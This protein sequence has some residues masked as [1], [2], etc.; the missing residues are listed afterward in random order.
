MEHTWN[1]GGREYPFDISESESMA[2]MCEG[3]NTLRGEIG[4]LGG[5]SAS[6]NLR[7]QCLIIRRFFDTVLGEGMGEAVCG[8][9]YSADVHTS[10]YMEFILFV[11]DQVNAFREKAA[12]VEEA[13]RNRAAELE[14]AGAY[15]A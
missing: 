4:M 12:A 8:T 3:L 5:D 11:S 13:Y 2:R 9:A 10:A 15:G 1:Y 14:P 7:G 6:E